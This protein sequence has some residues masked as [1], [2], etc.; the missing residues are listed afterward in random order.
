MRIVVLL[1]TILT[2]KVALGQ[3]RVIE[4]AAIPF[5]GFLSKADFDQRYPGEMITDLSEL[6]PG[7]YV[8]Y[9]HESLSYYFGPIL[10]QATGEDYLGQLTETVEAAVAQRPSIEDYRLDLS[11]EPSQPASPSQSQENSSADSSGGSGSPR[12]ESKPGLWGFLRRLF[13]F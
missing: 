13:G 4:E 1:L 2:A 7:W 12:P 10:L 8:I 6:S 11:Y 3:H 5:T 9:E